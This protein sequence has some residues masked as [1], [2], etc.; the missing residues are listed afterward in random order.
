[1]LS[2]TW[3]FRD[4][5]ELFPAIADSAKASLVVMTPFLDEVGAD[6]VLNLFENTA[7]PDKCLVLRT[8]RTGGP[9]EGLAKVQASL[10]QCGVQVLNFKLE[11]PGTSGTETF[12]AKVV[13]ADDMA[14]YVGSSN[15][16]QWSFQYSLELGLFVQGKAAS[17]IAGVMRAV[18]SVAHPL[19][20]E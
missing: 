3:G 10:A 9:P 12:H 7:A 4:T 5:K 14:A 16:N 2:G 20:T 19:A 8:T 1:M 17:R 15:M 18:R 11:K 6:I 13:L